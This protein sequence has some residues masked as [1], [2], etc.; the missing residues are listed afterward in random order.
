[1][2]REGWVK[3]ITWPLYVKR[4]VG[5]TYYMTSPCEDVPAEWGSMDGCH[6]PCPHILLCSLPLHLPLPEEQAIYKSLCFS[7]QLTTILSG[8]ESSSSVGMSEHKNWLFSGASPGFLKATTTLV[9]RALPMEWPT[10]LLWSSTVGK[11]I[12]RG[13]G[14]SENG[15]ISRL[16]VVVETTNYK[17]SSWHSTTLFGRFRI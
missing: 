5:K 16:T 15:S 12:F 6:R 2:W 8:L 14:D 7:G 13:G 17:I 11:C 9:S 4:G 3:H 1:M 10:V